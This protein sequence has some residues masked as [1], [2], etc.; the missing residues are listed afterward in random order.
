VTPDARAHDIGAGAI[1]VIPTYN[2]SQNLATII[3]RTF[4]SVPGVEVLVVDDGSPDGTGE[5]A[6]R[7]AASDGRVHVLHRA[8]KAGLGAAYLAGFRRSFERGYDTIIEMDAD[9]SHPPEK[10]PEMISALGAPGVGLVIGSRWTPGGRVIDWPRS[11]ELLS[12][13]ANAYARLALGIRVKDS[14]GGFR[15]YRASVLGSIDLSGIDS[16][17]YCFQVDLT[18]RVLSAGARVVE[19]PIDFR[20]REFGVSKMTGGIV[21]EAMSKVTAWGIGR[22]ASQVRRLFR[23]RVV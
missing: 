12:R 15:A 21:L 16:E 13:M 9:G 18:L 4:V 2:E 7:L 8:E 11:R 14:T 5:L 20:E 6:D 3:D 22:R 1:V 10:L 19:I 17:G 23:S